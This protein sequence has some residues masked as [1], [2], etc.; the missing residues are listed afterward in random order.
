MHVLNTKAIYQ[1]NKQN[2]LSIKS[3]VPNDNTAASMF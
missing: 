3:I 1:L 2:Q